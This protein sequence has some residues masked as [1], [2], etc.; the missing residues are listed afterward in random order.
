MPSPGFVFTPSSPAKDTCT[1]RAS[2]LLTTTFGLANLDHGHRSQSAKHHWPRPP[3]AR[4]RL[5]LDSLPTT[6]LTLHPQHLQQLRTLPPHQHHPVLLPNGFI[7]R[8]RPAP[9][10][11]AH[12][13]HNRNID[14]SPNPLSGHRARLGR[15]EANPLARLGRRAGARQGRSQGQGVRRRRREPV[16]AAGGPG[17]V[18]RRKGLEGCR[19]V[20]AGSVWDASIPLVEPD[21]RAVMFGAKGPATDKSRVGPPWLRTSDVRTGLE[22][23]STAGL[24]PSDS[25]ASLESKLVQA[26]SLQWLSLSTSAH[27][28]LDENQEARS[29]RTSLCC[30]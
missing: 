28:P 2:L 24:E 14:L 13:C 10:R 1:L 27:A 9:P 19:A 15:V 6:Q 18:P 3:R 29:P 22:I 23:E 17:W 26:K 12:R 4:V 16:C 20:T 21:F 11:T 30:E 7:T 25:R 5:A 8:A